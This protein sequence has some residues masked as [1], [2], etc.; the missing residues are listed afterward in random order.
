MTK[1][2]TN[3]NGAV[4]GDWETRFSYDKI[5]DESRETFESMVRAAT[6]ATEGYG[7]IGQIWAGYTK[8]AFEQGAAAAKTLIA[9]RTFDDV[10]GVQADYAKA[11]LDRYAVESG[12]ATDLAIKTAQDAM[13]PLQA[14]AAAA[15]KRFGLNA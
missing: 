8:Q 13:A 1:A 9:A 15:A 7:A 2:K 6:I 10:V 4:N 5:A 12:K 11:S 3:G 14:R